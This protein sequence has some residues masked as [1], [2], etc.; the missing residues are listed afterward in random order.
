[1]VVTSIVGLF[2]TMVTVGL[3]AQTVGSKTIGCQE[4]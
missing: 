2:G 3:I 1:M 4:E